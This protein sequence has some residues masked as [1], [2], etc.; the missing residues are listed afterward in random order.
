[1]AARVLAE[2][3]MIGRASDGFQPVQKIAGKS[4]RVYIV[5]PRIFDGGELES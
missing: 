3:G 1:M 5:T 4:M 2:R